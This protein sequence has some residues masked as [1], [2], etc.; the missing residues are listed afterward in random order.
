MY[1][2][3]DHC[4]VW[5][6]FICTGVLANSNLRLLIITLIVFVDVLWYGRAIRLLCWSGSIDGSFCEEGCG[7]L[8]NVATTSMFVV[9]LRAAS[10]AGSCDIQSAFPMLLSLQ[11]SNS[12]LKAESFSSHRAVKASGSLKIRSPWSALWSVM[13]L[14]C[15]TRRSAG[16][17]W[18]NWLLL[19][20]LALLQR[21]DFVFWWEIWKQSKWF[22]RGQ[23]PLGQGK[24]R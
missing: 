1:F 24:C 13:I 22:T 12:Y 14:N 16:S 19:K 10:V 2:L 18:C 4:E 23:S 15:W 8:S 11:C 7:C 17:F 21:S 20:F 9:M 3:I 6:W 5:C